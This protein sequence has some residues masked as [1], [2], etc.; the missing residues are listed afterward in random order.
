ML[1]Q[2]TEEHAKGWAAVSHRTALANE[3]HRDFLYPR[4]L[5]P[6]AIPFV[7]ASGQTRPTALEVALLSPL[8]GGQ[9][10]EFTALPQ[11]VLLV[12]L[13]QA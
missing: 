12:P 9:L 13:D 5:Q 3:R 10:E 8:F 2:A 11:L 7:V 4:A 6:L 1:L